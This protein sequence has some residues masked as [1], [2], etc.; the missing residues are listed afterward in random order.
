MK[1]DLVGLGVV[2]ASLPAGLKLNAGN[3]TGLDEHRDLLFRAISSKIG[4]VGLEE[5][6]SG[7]TAAPGLK[8]KAGRGGRPLRTGLLAT[9]LLSMSAATVLGSCSL[10]IVSV[11]A[12]LIAKDCRAGRLGFRG[13]LREWMGLVDTGMSGAM[14]KGD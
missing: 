8:E 3:A 2:C 13:I 7:K 5:P 4:W 14:S 9:P 6:L 10:S 12:G 1:L 11:A